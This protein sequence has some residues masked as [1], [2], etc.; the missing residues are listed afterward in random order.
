LKNAIEKQLRLFLQL[1]EDQLT[2]KF[3]LPGVS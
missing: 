1:P 2:L 3:D